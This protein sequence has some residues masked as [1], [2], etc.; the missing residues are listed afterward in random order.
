MFGSTKK[1]EVQTKQL[2]FDSYFDRIETALA[3]GQYEKADWL[4]EEVLAIDPNNA[5]A[6]FYQIL[7]IIFQ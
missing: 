5:K 6:Y 1:Q 4:L 3:K 7:V 2:S